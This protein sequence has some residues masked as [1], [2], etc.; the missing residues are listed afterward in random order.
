MFGSLSDFADRAY[1]DGHPYGNLFFNGANHGIDFFAVVLTDA[2]DDDLFTPAVRDSAEREQ[3]LAYIADH[4]I[5]RREIEVG[6]EDQ[7]VV[8]TTCTSE[9]TNGR[10]LLIGKLCDEVHLHPVPERPAVNHGT[11]VTIQTAQLTAV[12]LWTWLLGLAVLIALL[13]IVERKSRRGK[14]NKEELLP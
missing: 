12:P 6:P 13:I 1:F 2:Y 11:G 3:Y 14:Q 9:I 10:Y 8:L 5:H 7:L 4:A